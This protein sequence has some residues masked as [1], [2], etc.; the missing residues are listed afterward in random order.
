MLRDRKRI[1]V[2]LF[3]PAAV[4]LCLCALATPAAALEQARPRWTVTSVS[5][6]TNFAPSDPSHEQY[7][8]RVV[9]TNTGGAASDGSPVT[10]TDELPA[11]LTLDPAGA[12]GI[13]PL[14]GKPLTCVLNTCTF[15]GV[16]AP[17]EALTVSFPVDVLPGAPGS[18]T[19]VV[20]A[21]G[22]GA[23]GAS[24]STPTAITSTPASFG[25]APGGAT[26]ALSSTQAGAH[27]DLTTTIAFNTVDDKG[28][29]AGAPK[30]TTDLLPPGFAGD[31]VDTPSCTVAQFP[32]AECSIGSQIG[33]VK[34]DEDV[35]GE[36]RRHF[37]EPVFNLAPDPGD[38]AKLGIAAPEFNIEGVVSVDPST[39]RLKTTFENT[40]EGVA[41]LDQVSLSI[42]GIPADPIHDSLRL[43]ADRLGGASSSANP[44]A[45]LT[46]PTGC[47]G[48]PVAAEFF[49][50]SWEDPTHSVT[51]AMPFGP[52]TGCDALKFEPTLMA[53]ATSAA[54]SSPTGLD[55]QMTVPQ[56]Y[57]NAKG[58]ATST[59]KRAVV[60]LPEGMTVNP[61]A[62]SGL[63]GCTQAQYEEEAVEYV[64]GRGCPPEAKLGTVKIVTPAIKEEGSGS[65]FLAQ[66]YANPFGSL[67]SLYVVARFPQRGVLVRVAGQVSA[68]PLTG[69]LVTTFD[70]S[71]A[72]PVHGGLPPLPFNTF[73]FDFRQGQTSPLI[74]PPA[75]GQY[76][77]QAQLTPLA[78]PEEP[79]SVLAPSFGIFGGANGSACPSGGVP[80]LSP[81]LVAG[82]LDNQ[83]GSFSPMD[84]RI[85][86]NDGEQEIT[87]FA[88]QLPSGLTANLSGVARCSEA[89]VA[90]ART[91]TGAQEEAQ[92]SCPA[93][94]LIG[95]TLVGAGAGSVLAYAPGRLYLGAPFEGAP[96]SVVAITSAK[97]GPFDLGTVVVHLPLQ[98]DPLT[99][100]VSIPA[101]AADQIPHIIDGIVVHVRDIRV[102]VDRPNFMINPTNCE[103]QRL[104]A[105]VIGSGLSFT[106][107]ADDRSVSV[108][109]PFQVANCA[110]LAFKP[111]LTVSTSGKT[112]RRT[113]ASL[114]VELVYPKTPQGS[115]ANIRSVKVDLPKQ[116]PSQLKT[117]QQAC[118]DRVFNQNP[119]ACG[120][121]SRIGMANAT[122]PILPVALSGPVYF[123]SHGGA[124][125]P[126]LVI[127]LS[128]DGVTVQL[129]SETFI[130][131]AGITSSTFHAIPDVPVGTFELTLPQG[132]FPA[133]AANGNLCN[134][135][136]KMPTAFTAQNGAVIH[137]ST[138]IAVT[139]CARHKAKAK[140]ARHTGAHGHG[141]KP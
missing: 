109:D 83:A 63:Q 136:L 98:V 82:T 126:E 6:P 34:L 15:D 28:L 21:S 84:L 61:S 65:V 88:S 46:N 111:R 66:P 52:I 9:V 81:Q 41:E 104:S 91:K 12:S 39:Y 129:H 116:L 42:W 2:A 96:F 99:A 132:K 59:L 53:E 130:S 133:L 114:H 49:S 11:G 108:T 75:C 137:Q 107:P 57:D 38:V 89:D 95:H 24:M 71:N 67:I 8:Y 127:V 74:T 33:W 51:A 135:K 76:A 102:Y 87:G 16:V 60:T 73:T 124:K 117:L 86:R 70:T 47:T 31:L 14:T 44:S 7:Y 93:A 125:F 69:R 118:P 43:G 1:K 27:A 140:H 35:Q 113:G 122:T 68:D 112:S 54:A 128:G 55:L 45:Y 48:E 101:G 18:V 103:A 120:A 80:P 139:G 92:P 106:D 5:E 19:N 64:P 17:D 58:V 110:R 100:A 119:A 40:I 85:L 36:G 32:R 121:A 123:V 3:A 115:E 23:P 20:R 50:T 4:L 90:L 62:G 97:V 72:G 25:I 13:Q 105:T 138:P 56:T 22:G 131:K 141:G 30:N 79:A 10:V 134:Q 26:T 78:K 77:V 29:L 37:E 94:S